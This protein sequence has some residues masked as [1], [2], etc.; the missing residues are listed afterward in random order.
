MEVTGVTFPK[1]SGITYAQAGPKSRI[2]TSAHIMPILVVVIP[3]M[4]IMMFTV[5]AGQMVLGRMIRMMFRFMMLGLVMFA[6][7][8]AVFAASPSHSRRRAVCAHARRNCQNH[9]P[10]VFVPNVHLQ[11]P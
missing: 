4:I 1:G 9:G 8:P 10:L 11:F 7:M 6:A 2:P 3:V 5:M